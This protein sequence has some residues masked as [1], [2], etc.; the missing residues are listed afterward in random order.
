M[1]KLSLEA[2]SPGEGCTDIRL[3]AGSLEYQPLGPSE[4]RED[5]GE[6]GP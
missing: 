6:Q 2:L 4:Y 3:G 1:R 5:P